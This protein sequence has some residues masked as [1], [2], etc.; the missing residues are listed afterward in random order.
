MGRK[1]VIYDV[2]DDRCYSSYDFNSN[3]AEIKV[4]ANADELA[5]SWCKTYN[6]HDDVDEVILD[7]IEEMNMR[8]DISAFQDTR[9]VVL[10]LL[11]NIVQSVQQ[12]VLHFPFEI[13]YT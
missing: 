11:L 1:L 8:D 4:I 9:F 7:L 12:H 2:Q 3:D 5:E 13:D 10:R 6:T